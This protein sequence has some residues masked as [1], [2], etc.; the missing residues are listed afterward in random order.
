MNTTILMDLGKVIERSLT[1]DPESFIT[2]LLKNDHP[3]K[4]H[5]EA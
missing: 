5:K 1:M 3:E 4:I 2:N